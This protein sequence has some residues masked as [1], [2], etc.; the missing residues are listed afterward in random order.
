MATKKSTKTTVKKSTKAS[1]ARKTKAV[2]APVKR[3]TASKKKPAIKSF[4]VS[5]RDEPFMSMSLT[6]QS[7]YWVVLGIVVIAFAV[8][9]LKLQS[10]IQDI[11]D[12]IDYAEAAITY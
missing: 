5:P 7:L 1:A 12:S 2:K 8:W 9:I 10:D 11:Y 3:K 6:R 4:R